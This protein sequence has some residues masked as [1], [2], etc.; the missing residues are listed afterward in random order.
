MM[1]YR[2]R[3]YRYYVRAC[4]Q[5]LAPKTVKGLSPRAP[6]LRK[7]LRE[8]FPKNRNAAILDLGCGHGAF[9]HFMREAGYTN[10][11]G[12]DR[13]PEQV[14]EARRLGIDRVHEGD[15][16]ETLRSLP[17][18]SQDVVIA[19]DVI[20][21]FS[22][23][24]LLPLVDGV[25]RVLRRG[26]R[27]I[28]HAPN[29]QSPLAGRIRYG[30]LTHETIFTQVSISQL[31]Y[32][33]GFTEV[34]CREDTPIPHGLKSGVRWMLWKM[35]RSGLRLYLAAETGEAESDVIFTQNFLTI[36]VK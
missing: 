25:R 29:G 22:K 17:N 3:I 34:I 36:A 12:V 23:Q 14:A 19:F 16:T 30:D 1:D 13:S 27:W 18:D 9:V 4:S 35:I 33:S 24:E 11:V 8:H 31:L 26:G 10:V 7:I 32:S 2:S 5:P 21:H 15:L 20:E 28:I 6:Y